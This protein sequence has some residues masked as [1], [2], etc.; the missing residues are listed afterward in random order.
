[1]LPDVRKKRILQEIQTQGAAQVADLAELLGV[2]PMTVR[3]DLAELNEQGLVNRIHGGAEASTTTLEPAF[4]EKMGLNASEK[5]AIALTSLS[6]LHNSQAVAIAG[7]T[8]CLHIARA[9]A[10]DASFTEL[11]IIT[12]SLPVADEFFATSTHKVSP[13]R[14]LLTG[15]ERTPSDSLVGPLADASL[16]NLYADVLFIGTHGA[17]EAGLLTPNLQEAQTNRALIQ[18]AQKV[19]SVFDGSKWGT[20]GISRYAS[21]NDIDV[22][23]STPDLPTSAHTFLSD[24]V[25][26]VIIA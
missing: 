12:N 1:M 7:G 11:T 15:G 9:L 17:A 23:I 8:T 2:S 6:L 3:R 18:N 22:V 16:E 19:V 26:E 10:A 14:V 4:A 24:K 20:A 13:P 5:T 25:K 21:W